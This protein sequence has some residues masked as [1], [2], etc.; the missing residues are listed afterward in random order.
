VVIAAGIAAFDRPGQPPSR[1]C[2]C[3]NTIHCVSLK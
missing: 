2:G 3:R 1:F